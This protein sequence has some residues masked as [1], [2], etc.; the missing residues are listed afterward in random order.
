MV[1]IKCLCGCKNSAEEHKLIDCSVCKNPFI[2]S[3][4]DLTTTEV[5]TI[6]SKKGLSWSCRNCNILSNDIAE[7]KAAILGL[8]Q[9]LLNKEASN[10]NISDHTFELLLGELND[11][12]HRKQNVILFN[13]EESN[14]QDVDERHNHDLGVVR[15]VLS[16]CSANLNVDHVEIQRLGRGSAN[17]ERRRPLK[18]KL[19]CANDVHVVIKNSSKLR[20]SHIYRHLTVSFD[21][22]R[23]QIDYYKKIRAELDS[24]IEEGATDLKIKYKQGI[25]TIVS[26]NK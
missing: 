20:N 7:L 14:S 15:G 6:K 17:G 18:V 1:V 21:R 22:T 24:R 10:T 23:R 8:R 25:P 16:T 3:C 2:H 9:D 19:N 13:V 26:L 5:R 11:R 12:N 4:V